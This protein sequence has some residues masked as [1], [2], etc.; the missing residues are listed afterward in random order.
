MPAKSTGIVPAQ[1]SG[2]DGKL[3]AC[4]PDGFWRKG[5]FQIICEKYAIPLIEKKEEFMERVWERIDKIMERT[6]QG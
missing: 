3:V 5:N 6:S 4:C 2:K 1:S